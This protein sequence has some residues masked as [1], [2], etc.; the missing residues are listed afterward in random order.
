MADRE[1]QKS[2]KET[3]QVKDSAP[4]KVIATIWDIK[5]FATGHWPYLMRSNL[6]KVRWLHW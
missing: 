3:P 2:T 4:C 5:F 1:K 6:N